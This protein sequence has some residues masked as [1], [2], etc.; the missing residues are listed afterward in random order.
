MASR[1]GLRGNIT[2]S[3]SIEEEA[4]LELERSVL[5]GRYTWSWKGNL[6][7]KTRSIAIE[8]L[9]TSIFPGFNLC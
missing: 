7:D 5:F 1:T 2:E 8:I 4:F 9:L 6:V 3:I